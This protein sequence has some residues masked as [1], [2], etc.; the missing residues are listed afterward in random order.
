MAEFAIS[1]SITVEA[2]SYDEAYTIQNRLI[3]YL[4]MCYLVNTV[5][6]IDVEMTDDYGVDIDENDEV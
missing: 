2:D 6:E 4:D 3:D 1:L 5:T